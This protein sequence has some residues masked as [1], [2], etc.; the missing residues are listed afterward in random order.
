MKNEAISADVSRS[1]S[2]SAATSA[3]VRSS[4]RLSPPV[5]GERGGVGADVDGDLHEL[6]EIGGQVG[7]AEAEDDVGPVEDLLVVLVGDAH[8]VAD[9]LQR[10]RTGQLGDQFGRCRR[11]G[12]R[13]SPT[14][15]RRARSRTESSVRATT[16]G[17]KAL[18][19]MLRS[20][21]CRG[22]S[23]AIIE[24]KY[25]A[26]SGIWSPMVMFGYELKISG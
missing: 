22:S 23:S 1:P 4:P 10:Q 11:D 7:V 15:S 26:T 3:V 17:V 24:P 8:H 20:R 25:S 16:L 6:V 19:T 5:L 21:A 14:T 12:S 2:T 13:S 9:H 18:R